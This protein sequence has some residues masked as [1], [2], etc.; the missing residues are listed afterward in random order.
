MANKENAASSTNT[1]TKSNPIGST[2]ERPVYNFI[3]VDATTGKA[4]ENIVENN[5][6]IDHNKYSIAVPDRK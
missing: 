1:N 5:S 2:V 3:R 4:V 6:Y